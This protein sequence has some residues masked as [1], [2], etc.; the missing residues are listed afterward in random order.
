[1]TSGLTTE[2]KLHAMFRASDRGSKKGRLRRLKSR[3][4]AWIKAM[5]TAATSRKSMKKMTVRTRRNFSP[6]STSR[7]YLNWYSKME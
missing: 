1:M 2:A 7:M 5:T 6:M 3:K 4:M